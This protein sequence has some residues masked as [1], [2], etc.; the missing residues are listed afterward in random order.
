MTVES[1]RKESA[2]KKYGIRVI[3]T[4]LFYDAEGNELFRHQGFFSR[5]DILKTWTEH[6]VK[7]D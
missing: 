4:Q 6:G 3:P 2:G 1:P 5:E 7:F